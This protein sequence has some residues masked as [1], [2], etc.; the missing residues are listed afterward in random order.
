MYAP[1][2][3]YPDVNRRAASA[4]HASTPAARESVSPRWTGGLLAVGALIT[5]VGT[6]LPFEKIIAFHHAVPVATVTFTGV[7]AKSA[8]GL[9]ISGL[10]GGN[11]GKLI[12]GLAVLCAGAL[13]LAIATLGAPAGDAKTLNASTGPD[14]PPTRSPGPAATSSPRVPG[15]PS[16]R[17]CSRS[18]CAGVVADRCGYETCADVVDC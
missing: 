7:G 16:S 3:V 15:S 17:R 11:G 14:G 5:A 18:A 9:P 1:M 6:F 12:L 13:V 4:V 10:E 2:N 8:T